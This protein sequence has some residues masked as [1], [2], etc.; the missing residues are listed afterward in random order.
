MASQ[1]AEPI[2][3]QYRTPKNASSLVDQG[4]FPTLI[5]P[6]RLRF[7]APEL[8]HKEDTRIG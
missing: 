8:H 7:L 4:S 6:G 1:E 3:Y 2:Y 5:A